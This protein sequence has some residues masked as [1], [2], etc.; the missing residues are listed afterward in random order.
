MLAR[1]V[2][3]AVTLALL[4][5]ACASVPPPSPTPEP[6]DGESEAPTAS[7]TPLPSVELPGTIEPG[8]IS[9]HLEALAAIAAD[10]GGVR[11]SGTP[12]Y[13]ASVAY[14]ADELR[15]LGY[16]VT[17]PDVEIDTF[18]ELAGGT[19]SVEDAATA[20]TSGTDF[21]AMIY[22]EDGEITAPVATVGYVDS[23]GGQGNVGCDDDDWDA[24]PAGSIAV[25]PPGPCF[26]RQSLLHA[27]DA[28]AVAVVVAYED[29]GPGELLRPTLLSPDGIEIP[30]LTASDEV[31][32][33]LREAADD[34]LEVRIEVET[35]VQPITVQ[36]VI[37]DAPG[38]DDGRVA[39]LGA[40]LDS[41][42]DGPGINDNGSGTAALL[43]I[44]ELLAS[45]EAGG[46]VRFGF[47]AAEEFGVLGSSAYVA[48]LDDG[49]RSALAAYLNLD[50]L[51]SVNAVPFVYR[52]SAAAPGSGDISNFLVSWLETDGIGAEE[53]D[54]SNGSDHYAFTEAGIP[55]GGIFSGATE[56]MTA[57]QAE[58]FEGTA[59]EPM[60]PCYHLPCDG[61]TNVDVEQVATF[62]EAA[63]AAALALARGDLLGD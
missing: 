50:M 63:A 30:S 14:V 34:G 44:A 27:Q 15:A 55:V 20:F 53:L 57:S 7:T 36:N 21:K 1:F 45:T 18:R 22:S 46:T 31:G 3:L 43:A 35:E 38:G 4:L 17:T 62:A 40:H 9:R 11:T 56:R 2:L 39:M 12:G 29:R 61:V 47:W 10:H 60:D 28:G 41:V 6:A 49:E 24:F 58:E 16:E 5:A 42:H 51:G 32:E 8:T 25:S 59:G 26:R 37:A 54:L 33:A 52:N 13:D 19:L 48:A 23:E